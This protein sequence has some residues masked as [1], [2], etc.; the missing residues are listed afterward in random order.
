MAGSL[1]GPCKGADF[2]FFPLAVDTHPSPGPGLPLFQ[3]VA[4]FC[5]RL[6]YFWGGEAA[7]AG[8]GQGHSTI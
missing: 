1:Q 6:I 2:C 3:A 4:M 8:A 7:F 5:S